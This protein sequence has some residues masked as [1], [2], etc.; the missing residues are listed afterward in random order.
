VKIGCDYKLAKVAAE[1]KKLE[2]KMQTVT[3]ERDRRI[4]ELQDHNNELFNKLESFEERYNNQ[5]DVS[6]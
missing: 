2:T 3:E 4:H 5:L 6:R 1:M